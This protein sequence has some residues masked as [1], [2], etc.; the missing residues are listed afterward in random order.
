MKK[1]FS[2]IVSIAAIAVALMGTVA[3]CVGP[4]SNQDVDGGRCWA[5]ECVTRKGSWVT[6]EVDGEPVLKCIQTFHDR[7]MSLVGC[8]EIE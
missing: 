7:S 2:K 4:Q 5:R 3:S 1:Y 6:I 8:K